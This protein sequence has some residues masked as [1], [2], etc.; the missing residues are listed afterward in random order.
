[1]V[2]FAIGGA[3]IGTVLEL[4]DNGSSLQKIVFDDQSKFGRKGQ[5]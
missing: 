3:V 5:Q 1:M 2:T 4:L